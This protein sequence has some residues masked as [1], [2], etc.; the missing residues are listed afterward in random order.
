VELHEKEKMEL[1]KQVLQ[2]Q[3]TI[4][5]HREQFSKINNDNLDLNKEKEKMEKSQ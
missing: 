1:N 3:T 5:L 4:D 2:K